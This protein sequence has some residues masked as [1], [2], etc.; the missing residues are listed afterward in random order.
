MCTTLSRILAE[1]GSTRK[2]ETKEWLRAGGCG[3]G[4]LSQE[5]LEC[6]YS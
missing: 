4:F 6:V 5:R 3:F 1:K 2:V